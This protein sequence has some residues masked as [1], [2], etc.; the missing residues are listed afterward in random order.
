[1]HSLKKLL[2]TKSLLAAAVAA[3]GI[4]APAIGQ[5]ARTLEPQILGTPDDGNVCRSGYG[6]SVSGAVV[7]CHKSFAIKT[8]LACTN[9]TF[10]KYVIRA[11]TDN[12]DRTNGQ[13][14]CIKDNGLQIG[15]TDT[16]NG[17]TESVN[18]GPGQFAY[19]QASSTKLAERVS[20]QR[21]AEAT[22]L[23]LPLSQ[24]DTKVTFTLVKVNANGLKDNAES[25]AHHYTFLIPNGGLIGNQGP[26]GLPATANTTSAFVPRP[27]PR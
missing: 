17:L 25:Q 20:N 7:S 11:A 8:D 26:I 3:S 9:P 23:G 5:T 13:D 1:M 19:A 4:S 22:A 2:L 21:Q 24:V 12:F 18:G 14:I 16:L 10:P 15:T 6:M 27:L